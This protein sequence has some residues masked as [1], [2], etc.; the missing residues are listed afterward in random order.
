MCLSHVR[1]Y[2]FGYWVLYGN[3]ILDGCDD[4][5]IGT[6][7]WFIQIPLEI[8]KWLVY[9]HFTLKDTKALA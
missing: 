6:T 4:H 9:K 2:L 8:S 5:I 7:N 1:Y 3:W